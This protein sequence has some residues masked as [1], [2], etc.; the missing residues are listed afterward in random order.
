M[1]YGKYFKWIIKKTCKEKV[2]SDRTPYPYKTTFKYVKKKN[3]K[4]NEDSNL[5]K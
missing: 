4:T 2:F 1:S 5:N 3:S